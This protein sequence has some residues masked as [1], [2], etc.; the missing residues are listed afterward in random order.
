MPETI[1]GFAVE[2]YTETAHGY[3]VTGEVYQ[4]YQERIAREEN[5]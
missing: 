5:K 3:A 2:R 4:A 1:L